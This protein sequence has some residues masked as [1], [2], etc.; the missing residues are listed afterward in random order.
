MTAG[1]EVIAQVGCHILGRVSVSRRDVLKLAAA[2]P[3]ALGLGA[4]GSAI[5]PATASAESLGVLLDYA[6]GV[7]SA[8]DLKA[9][10]A[11]G[12]IRYVSDRRPGGDWMLGQAD[13]AAPKPAT[14]TR[15]A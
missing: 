12:A 11:L 10:G 6:A 9:S 2:T 14:C 7:I 3:A 8:A 13:S 1:D 5:T 15:P 4:L